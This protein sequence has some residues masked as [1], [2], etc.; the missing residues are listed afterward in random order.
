MDP[1]Q[2]LPQQLALNQW[3]RQ[4][5][6]Q[7]HRLT[8]AAPCCELLL[9]DLH[10]GTVLWSGSQLKKHLVEG[11]GEGRVMISA[12]RAAQAISGLNLGQLIPP[13]WA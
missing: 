7:G 2:H 12:R 1:S 11:N 3:F 8:L 5:G 9:E 10:G 4:T 6:D 13:R